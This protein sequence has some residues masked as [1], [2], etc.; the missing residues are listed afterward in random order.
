MH[1]IHQLCHSR[2]SNIKPRA[3]LSHQYGAL[4]IHIWRF[5]AT[6]A[7]STLINDYS[8]QSICRNENKTHF[9]QLIH[10]FIFIFY[11]L[12]WNKLKLTA[13]YAIN[14]PP[15]QPLC[16]HRRLCLTDDDKRKKITIYIYNSIFDLNYKTVF[17]SLFVFRLS[18][19][20][21][22]K[23]QNLF[24]YLYVSRQAQVI[25]NYLFIFLVGFSFK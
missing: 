12:S 13:E 11:E 14:L 4:Y 6:T 23:A 25:L 19:W 15:T 5:G 8:H 24:C 18:F 16:G 10:I 2:D 7:Q 9:C 22:E 3:L 1:E 21:I 20:D 17:A